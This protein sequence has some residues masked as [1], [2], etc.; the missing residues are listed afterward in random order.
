MNHLATFLRF[1]PAIYYG[2]DTLTQLLLPS[3]KV[4]KN[5]QLAIDRF[6]EIFEQNKNLRKDIRICYDD[7]PYTQAFGTNFGPTAVLRVNE[8]LAALKGL[9]FDH[10]CKRELYYIKSNGY[11]W[12]SFCAMTT[13]TVTT[14]AVIFFRTKL[15]RWAALGSEYIPLIV[16]LAVSRYANSFFQKKADEFALENSTDDELVNIA[17]FVSVQCAINQELHKKYPF[18]FSENGN[19]GLIWKG[20]TELQLT[21]HDRILSALQKRVQLIQTMNPELENVLGAEEAQQTV[22]LDDLVSDEDI[23]KF[24]LGVYKNHVQLDVSSLQIL[25]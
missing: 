9:S 21:N 10:L 8:D 24:H 15:P 23:F 18:I 22:D 13:A 17:Q 12:S 7:V 2:Y 20:T 16:S 14:V 25:S 6:P 19:L 4:A 1:V 11:F 5:Q 3:R